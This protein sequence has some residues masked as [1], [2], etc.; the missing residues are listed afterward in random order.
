MSPIITIN[1]SWLVAAIESVFT[2][3]T[4]A[5]LVF[6]KTIVLRITILVVLAPAEAMEHGTN[7]FMMIFWIVFKNRASLCA[8]CASSLD[9]VENASSRWCK[10]HY[11][12]RVPCAPD[13]PPCLFRKLTH[14]CLFEKEVKFE[15]HIYLNIEFEQSLLL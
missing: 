8:L 15:T 6:G 3:W 13:A 11:K 5:I 7:C 4:W 1:L 2:P 10:A 14:A 9:L 12:R